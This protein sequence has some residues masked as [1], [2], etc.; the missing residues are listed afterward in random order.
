MGSVYLDHRDYDDIV[1]LVAENGPIRKVTVSGRSGT[2]SFNELS[3]SLVG[4]GLW[5]H[6][7]GLYC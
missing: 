2:V 6:C 1:C 5:E 3:I 4:D 7:L